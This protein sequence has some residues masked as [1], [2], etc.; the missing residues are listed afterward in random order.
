[1]H[2]CIHAHLHAVHACVRAYMH[3][4]HAHM[5][6]MPTY[7]QASVMQALYSAA[8]DEGPTRAVL[9]LAAELNGHAPTYIHTCV[10]TYMR[11]RIRT[12]VHAGA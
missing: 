6:Y 7:M 5:R 8:P 9:D 12:Y 11:T 1:M 3:A 4:L 2:A 10:H